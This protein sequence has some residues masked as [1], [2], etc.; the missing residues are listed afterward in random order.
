[1]EDFDQFKAVFGSRP[2]ITYDQQTIDHVL[3]NRR[4]LENELFIDRLLKALGVEKGKSGLNPAFPS[5][6]SC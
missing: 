2:D 3:R 1:M 4:L 6:G 5:D